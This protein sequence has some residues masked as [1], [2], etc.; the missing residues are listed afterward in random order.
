MQ[1]AY[2]SRRRAVL[3]YGTA[4]QNVLS[5]NRRIDGGPIDEQIGVLRVDDSDGNAIA[6]LANLAAHPTTVPE[7]DLFSFSSDY[8]HFF[9]KKMEELTSPG[10]VAMFANGAQG[11]QRT[12]N[13]ENAAGWAR[14]ESI[15]RLLAIRVK[16]AA[17]SIRSGPATLRLAW[18]EPELPPT[19]ADSIQPRTVLLQ[20][21]EVNGLLLTFVP[22]EPCVEIGLE[23]RRRA[24]ARGY[25]AQFTIGLAN[26]YLNYFVT[27][28]T[29]HRLDYEC[30]MNFFGPGISAWLYREFGHLMKGEPEPE[31]DVRT[32]P[33]RVEEIDGAL[34]VE[35]AGTP[36]EIG[37]QRGAAFRE[38]IVSRYERKVAAPLRDGDL[39]PA[40]GLWA[41][42]P[43]F[44]DPAPLALP[45]AGIAA[46]P[47]LEGVSPALFAELRG[48]ADGAGIPFDALWLAQCVPYLEPMRDQGA[49]FELP[50]CTMFAASRGD[51]VIVGRNL[52]W[53]EDEI[54]VVTEIVPAGGRAFAQV[55]FP[56]NAGV[57][58]GMNESGLVLC[59]ERVPGRGSP[60]ARGR[61]L[62]M[63]LRDLLAAESS[64]P[65]A[66]DA[67]RALVH[68]RG[69]HVLVA[70]GTEAAVVEFGEGITVRTAPA[71]GLLLGSLPGAADLDPDARARYARLHALLRDL[72]RIGRAEAAEAL[73]DA[74]VNETGLARIWNTQTR[75]SVVF[76]PGAARLHVAFPT[77][78]GRPGT[79]NTIRVLPARERGHE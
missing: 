68:V 47:L 27:P 1:E 12:G 79:F 66:V 26:D 28:E 71:D 10:C 46:R 13:P 44:I 34:R 58:T 48:M 56:W 73:A 6:I 37:S 23:L 20:V 22:G 8:A 54:P 43:S 39:L 62:E 25:D 35:L 51:T 11:D 60:V 49:L 31:K 75:H 33:A 21:L 30:G 53:P 42:I 76:E 78:H 61:P 65:K 67:L 16:E 63:A 74:W 7:E 57:F 59:A 32:G 4:K 72:T 5:V 41:S 52:D 69:Y 24:L 2:Q 14:T 50:F 40:E 19:L 45:V 3:G 55:G 18:A 17:N 9:Y 29:Y 36:Y 77:E 15:G 70:S 38:E 64:V